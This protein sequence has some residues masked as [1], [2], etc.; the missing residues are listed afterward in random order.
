MF[1]DFQD[2]LIT[3]L[4]AQVAVGKHLEGVNI[5][6]FGDRKPSAQFHKAVTVD[7]DQKVHLAPVG[8]GWQPVAFFSVAIYAT[9]PTSEEL[10]DKALQDLLARWTSDK[11]V[12][13]LPCLMAMGGVRGASGRQYGFDILPEMGRGSLSEGKRVFRMGAYFVIQAY[14]KPVT[15][16]DILPL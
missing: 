1:V 9:D 13:V 7:W 5:V 15:T 3:A 2:A 4:E 11:L 14:C 10:A 8:N 16:D 6:Q 12:G